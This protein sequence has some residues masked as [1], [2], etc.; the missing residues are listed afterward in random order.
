MLS[1]PSFHAAVLTLALLAGAA[2]APR[3]SAQLVD[4][5]LLSVDNRSYSQRQFELYMALESLLFSGKQP[6]QWRV[7]P[8]NWEAKLGVFIQHMLVDKSARSLATFTA[9]PE[10]IDI[11]VRKLAQIKGPEWREF[12][13]SLGFSPASFAAERDRMIRVAKFVCHRLRLSRAGSVAYSAS[14]AA[15]ASCKDGQ[16]LPPLSQDFRWF[17]RIVQETPYRVYEGARTYQALLPFP[18]PKAKIATDGPRKPSKES[19][20]EDFRPTPR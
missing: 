16:Q 18:Q 6:A 5:L 10:E 4:R 8:G 19:A 15:A 7:T 2:A 11:A 12:V 13:S 14:Q 20:Y 9:K 1:S 3:A 17:K